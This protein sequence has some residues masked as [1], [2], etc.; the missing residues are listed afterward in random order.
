MMV[1]SRLIQMRSLLL[2][3]RAKLNRQEG[4]RLTNQVAKA[5]NKRR[6]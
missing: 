3:M 1:V 4:K 5:G 2:L 6:A